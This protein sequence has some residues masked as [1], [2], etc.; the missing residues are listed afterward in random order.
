MPV[1]RV[2]TEQSFK[3]KEFYDLSNLA[4][5]VNRAYALNMKLDFVSPIEHS[6]RTWSITLVSQ[7]DLLLVEPGSGNR[8]AR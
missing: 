6:R 7:E 1:E 3:L 2:V 5:V 8:I 4:G